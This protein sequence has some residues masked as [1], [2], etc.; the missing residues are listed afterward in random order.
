MDYSREADRCLSFKSHGEQIYPNYKHL[1]ETGLYFL[2]STSNVCCFFCRVVL[3]QNGCHLQ[4]HIKESPYC[5]LLKR[6]VTSNKPLSGKRIDEILP[7]LSIDV[8]GIGKHVPSK[9]STF[10][11]RIASFKGWPVVIKQTPTRLAKAGLYY[12]GV[13]DVVKCFHCSVEISNWEP[14]DNPWIEH[15][16]FSSNCEYLQMNESTIGKEELCI[17]TVAAKTSNECSVCLDLTATV[18]LLP[19]RH[20]CVCGQCVF[21]LDGTCPICREAVKGRISLIFS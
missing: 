9:L 5:P 8:C 21:V 17:T 12:S 19:C 3:H 15:H 18:V 16:K 2:S 1:A 13:G 14:A 4:N 10:D 11:Q 6:R 20:V 7:P